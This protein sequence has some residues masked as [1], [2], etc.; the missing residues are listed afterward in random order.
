[1]RV[2]TEWGSVTHQALDMSPQT[3]KGHITL[4]D[5][6]AHLPDGEAGGA[7]AA[8][9]GRQGRVPLPTLPGGSCVPVPKPP[10][11]TKQM[12]LRLGT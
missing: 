9:E 1:M 2:A 7:A 5:G 12:L 6:C 4:T 3:H 8:Q 11:C 10:A